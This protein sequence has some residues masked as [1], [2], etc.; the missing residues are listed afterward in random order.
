MSEYLKYFSG[1]DHQDLESSEYVTQITLDDSCGA[2]M[3]SAIDP[4]F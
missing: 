1:L 3:D 4:H 2:L